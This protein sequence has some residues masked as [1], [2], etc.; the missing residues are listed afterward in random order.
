MGAAD[1]RL[2]GGPLGDSG[3]PPPVSA[4]IAAI[5]LREVAA[6]QTEAMVL[7]GPA[8]EG[9]DVLTDPPRGSLRGVRLRNFRPNGK[10]TSDLVEWKSLEPEPVEAVPGDRIVSE[11]W[12]ASVNQ[13]KTRRAVAI[14]YLRGV[15]PICQAD[16]NCQAGSVDLMP[17]WDRAPTNA[18]GDASGT[19]AVH[20]KGDDS[21]VA[22]GDR[23]GVGEETTTPGQGL[24]QVLAQT[25]KHRNPR[26]T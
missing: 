17:R 13:S 9:S 25:S 8:E 20:A 15:V 16:S 6:G 4:S 10:S 22:K 19:Q 23:L 26:M 18:A 2:G 11:T 7:R 14:C 5:R 21:Q 1:K 24:G 3:R 12:D